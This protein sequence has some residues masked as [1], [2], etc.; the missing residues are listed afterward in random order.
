MGM[1]KRL[2]MASLA[3][4]ATMFSASSAQAV[5]LEFDW[6]L[7]LDFSNPSDPTTPQTG[8]FQGLVEIAIPDEIEVLTP[9]GPVNLDPLLN[10]PFPAEGEATIPIEIVELELRS[11]APVDLNGFEPTLISLP[12]ISPSGTNKA[13][14]DVQSLPTG[15]TFIVDSFYDVFFDITVEEVDPGT[16]IIQTEIVSLSLQGVQPFPGQFPPEFF[17]PSLGAFDFSGVALPEPLIPANPELPPLPD[18]EGAR[19]VN[20]QL[21]DIREED[22]PVPGSLALLLLPL[23]AILRRRFA[24]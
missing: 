11:V 8:A 10:E 2:Q 13:E 7:E 23:A 9:G 5:I 6:A 3:V 15:E 19:L 24:G 20:S 1:I 18:V 21:M 17:L 4:A 22:I 12:D 16:G 14:L